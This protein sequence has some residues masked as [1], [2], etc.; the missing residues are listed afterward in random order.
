LVWLHNLL[1][2][3]VDYSVVWFFSLV[4]K[5]LK[6]TTG[7]KWWKLRRVRSFDTDTITVNQHAPAPPAAPGGYVGGEVFSANMLAVLSPYLALFS[8]VAV[9]A[10]LVKRR[11]I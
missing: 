1:R 9:A 4:Y 11:K 2:H 8:V 5:L 7:K 10:V 6:A 3:E